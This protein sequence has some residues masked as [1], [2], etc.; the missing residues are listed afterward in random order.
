M[1]LPQ[2]DYA[3]A[4]TRRMSVTST[5]VA[6]TGRAAAANDGH[7]RFGP[8]KPQKGALT[9][10]L[11][12]LNAALANRTSRRSPGARKQAGTTD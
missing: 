1:A 5:G 9:Q 2:H 10:N 11:Q 7:Q 12:P 8:S 6:N 3:T 4:C